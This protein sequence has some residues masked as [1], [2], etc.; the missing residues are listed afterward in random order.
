MIKPMN[1]EW[2]LSK[3]VFCIDKI[4]VHIDTFVEVNLSI[5]CINVA[6]WLLT[7]K[8]HVFGWVCIKL[9]YLVI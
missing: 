4:N 5:Y 2:S 3:F 9:S 1:N 7:F 8:K 6:S